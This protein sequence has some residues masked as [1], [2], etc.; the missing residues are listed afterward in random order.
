LGLGWTSPRYGRLEPA[1]ML[2]AGAAGRA[3]IA[4]VTVFGG[5]EPARRVSPMAVRPADDDWHRIGVAVDWNGGVDVFL[6]ATE[7]GRAGARPGVPAHPRAA[8][9]ATL[10]APWPTGGVE[11]DARVAAVRLGPTGAIRIAEQ[12]GGTRLRASALSLAG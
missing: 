8:A 10:P 5:G 6:F 2:A 7:R 3:P 12:V 4:I 1:T 11:T 9:V